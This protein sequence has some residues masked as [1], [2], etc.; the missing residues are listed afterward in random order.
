MASWIVHLPHFLKAGMGADIAIDICIDDPN[1]A[2]ITR[3]RK[4]ELC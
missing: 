2:Y 4:E 1:I 3:E